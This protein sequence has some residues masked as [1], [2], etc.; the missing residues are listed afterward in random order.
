MPKYLYKIGEVSEMLDLTAST[1]RYWVNEYPG[2][3]SASTG[4]QR[5]YTRSDINRIKKFKELVHDRKLRITAAI[6]IMS[7][8]RKY[9]P[10]RP[11]KCRDAE[12]A[13]KLLSDI[14]AMTDSEHVLARVK[15]L[16]SWIKQTDSGT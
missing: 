8:D 3:V 2:L 11:P 16:Q 7:G 13:L 4:G 5:R 6:D 14:S 10:K 15:A 9:Q 12:T 1:L